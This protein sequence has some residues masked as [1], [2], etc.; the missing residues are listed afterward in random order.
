MSDRADDRAESIRRRIRDRLRERGED[1]QFGLQRYA[2]ERFLFR[3]GDSPHREWFVLKGAT[4][5]ALW[6]GTAYRPTR[7]IDFAGFGSAV[8]EDVLDAIRDICLH[9]TTGDAAEARDRDGERQR[10]MRGF[11]DGFPRLTVYSVPH[12]GGLSLRVPKTSRRRM[13]A[14]WTGLPPP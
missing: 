14:E 4:L 6:S 13:P 9:P 1:V 3:L 10:R 8:V 7:D 11:G 5:F 2:T 12:D